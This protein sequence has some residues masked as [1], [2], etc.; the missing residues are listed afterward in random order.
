[1]LWSPIPQKNRSQTSNAKGS[2]VI[3]DSGQE[4]EPSHQSSV[5]CCVCFEQSK[6][7]TLLCTQ[8]GTIYGSRLAFLSVTC[9][10]S[11]CAG[12]PK[13]KSLSFA[14]SSFPALRTVP[15]IKGFSTNAYQMTKIF[16]N[17]PLWLVLWRKWTGSSEG[18][19]RES[20]NDK[21]DLFCGDP[22][23]NIGWIS[24]KPVE[25]GEEGLWEPEGP[26]IP[27]VKH[28]ESTGLGSWGLTETELPGRELGW[29]WPGPPARCCSCVAW[30]SC[31]NPSRGIRGRFWL[32]CL[33]VGPF[34]P[35]W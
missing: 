1:M 22:Q 18:E 19:E 2:W 32:C 20:G 21:K 33:L 7:A 17:L 26:T 13:D 29:A 34:P 4:S 11:H 15:E 8:W 28:L 3:C 27:Q 25:D 10:H 5:A 6:W 16:K 35:A 9:S 14:C 12:R 31:R 23:P 24:G 30:S